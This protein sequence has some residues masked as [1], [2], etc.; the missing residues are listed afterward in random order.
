MIEIE[1]C[2]EDVKKLLKKPIVLVGMMGVGKTTVGRQLAAKLGWTFYDSDDEIVRSVGKSI[3][4]IFSEDGEP[5]FRDLERTTIKHLLANGPCVISS[6]G[7]GITIPE[8]AQAIKERS[9]C[10]WIDAS[11][12]LLVERTAGGDRPLLKH[13]DPEEVLQMLLDK[14][15]SSYA[16]AHVHALDDGLTPEEMTNRILLQIREYLY[17]HATEKEKEEFVPDA[18]CM[19]V[20]LSDR[21]YP[22]FIGSGLLKEPELWLPHELHGRDTFILTDYNVRERITDQ[23]QEILKPIMKSVSVMEL[24]PGEQTKSFERYQAVLEW[25][26]ESGVKRDSLIIA[27]GGGVVGDLAGFAAAT[28]LRGIDFIQVPTTLLSQVDSSVG[29]KT[30]INSKSAKNMIGAF[31][32]PRS[33]VIDLDTLMTL[34]KREWLSGYAEIVKYGL[35]ADEGFFEWL[36]EHGLLMLSGETA[37]AMRAIETSCHMKAEIVHKDEREESGLRALLNFGHTFAH[38]LEAAAGYDGTLLHGE[39]VSVGMVLAA[40]LSQ[41]LGYLVQDDVNRIYN[42]LSG[43]GL[44]TEIRNI[45]FKKP[46]TADE[47]IET[48]HKDKKA[49]VDGIKFIVLRR[50]GSAAVEAGVST[51]TVKNILEESMR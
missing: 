11:V 8:T 18:L 39:A 20:S 4:D 44:M 37:E 3:S 15:R 1:H 50:I 26:I 27:V 47:L 16:Q 7:G 28:I 40:R 29:G 25:M 49:G 43:L 32:Q 38:A 10:L 41:R 21:S 17:S 33:V 30:G 23:F 35:I 36:E 22:I 51:E 46:V 31:Y 5:A 6:G 19:T 12:P 2:L 14:R 9:L 42:H 45:P 34:P 24:A 13:G 48:M